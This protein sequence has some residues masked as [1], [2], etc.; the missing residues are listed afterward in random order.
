MKYL[1]LLGAVL[2]NAEVVDS[3]VGGFTVKTTVNIKAVPGD[4]YRRLVG[5]VGEWWN[6]AHTFSQDSHNLRIEDRP[7]GCFCEKLPNNGFVRHL[8][9]ILA[10]PG[11]RIVMSG[12]F[13]PLQHLA[14]TGSMLIQ[15]LPE[16]GN[17]KL[18]VT[19]RVTGYLPPPGMGSWAVPVDMVLTEQFTRLKEFIETGKAASK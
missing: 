17:T 11:N 5:N 12:A 1:L 13:G 9:V 16:A 14:A 3:A 4:V 8:E 15:F 19:Y 2:A 7:G 10:M 18:E 6:P